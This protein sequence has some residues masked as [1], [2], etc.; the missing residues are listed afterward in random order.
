MTTAP[1]L[2][3]P[4]LLEELGQHVETLRTTEG[5]QRWL[6]LASRFRTY[7]LRNQLLI[8]AQRPDA[9]RVAGYRAWQALGRQ[10]KRGERGIAILA[11][12]VRRREEDDDAKAVCGF[13]V[14]RVFDLAQTEGEPL[15]ELELPPVQI[16]DER[17]LDRLIAAT[18]AAG[19]TVRTVP[20]AEDR[21]RGWWDPVLRRITLVDGFEPANRCRTLL[22]E[23]GHAHDSVSESGIVASRA[24]RELVAESV[25][26]LVGRGIGLDL[27]DAS[28]TYVASWGGGAEAIGALAE[29]VLGV[30][31]AVEQ[32]IRVVLEA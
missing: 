5:W 18:E 20:S 21:V 15:A 25:A 27:A 14:V 28:A 8:L 2:S 26:Y 22:H 12:I 23:L 7:S 10:V 4:Q 30:A 17:L 3:Y 29:H 1:S 16:S 6:E 19:F 31:A 9:T 13:R 32:T 24:E 11:P